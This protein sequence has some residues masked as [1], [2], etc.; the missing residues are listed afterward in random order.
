MTS[1]PVL[2]GQMGIE[3]LP[4]SPQPGGG[5]HTGDRPE[6]RSRARRRVCSL[7]LSIIPKEVQWFQLPSIA[8]VNG[9]V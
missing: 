9:G 5:G 4:T 3:G 7:G 6:R 1:S 2:Q 8:S